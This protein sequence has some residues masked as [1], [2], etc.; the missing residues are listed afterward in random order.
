[1]RRSPNGKP[2]KRLPRKLQRQNLMTNSKSWGGSRK[3][4]GRPRG[5][6]SGDQHRMVFDLDKGDYVWLAERA[7]KRQRTLASILR[8]AVRFYRKSQ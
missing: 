8:E 6:P 3:G 1:M 7:A 2:Q 5:R 4:A